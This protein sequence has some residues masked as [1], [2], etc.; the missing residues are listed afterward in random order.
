MPV[1]FNREFHIATA[2]GERITVEMTIEN[3]ETHSPKLS[4]FLDPVDTVRSLSLVGDATP[5]SWGQIQD[6]L[7]VVFWQDARIRKLVLLWNRWH[8]NDVVPGTSH[9][10]FLLRDIPKHEDRVTA[11]E[12]LNMHVDQG[13]KY[14]SAWLY[15]PLPS[16]VLESL[17]S[18]LESLE[19][20]PAVVDIPDHAELEV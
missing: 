9:Q 3:K 1:T 5:N 11:L 2:N 18:T 14:G 16:Y 17:L 19:R 8:L 12:F 4:V 20:K 13:Y 6:M 10:M 7:E 15:E